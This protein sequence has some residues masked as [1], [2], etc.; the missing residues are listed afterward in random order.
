MNHV[1]RAGP[2][3]LHTLAYGAASVVLYTACRLGNTKP[4]LQKHSAAATLEA[5]I[6][7]LQPWLSVMAPKAC[8]PAMYN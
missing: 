7:K 2:G 6:S 5:M 3:A 1:M 8:L 4:H